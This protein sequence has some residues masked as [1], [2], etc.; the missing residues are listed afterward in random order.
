MWE[1]REDMTVVEYRVWG[2]KR[3]RV[4][5]RGGEAGKGEGKE[6]RGGGRGGDRKESE[7]R[8]VARD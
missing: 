3:E 1:C 4:R 2:G 6:R 5:E 7:G 8:K